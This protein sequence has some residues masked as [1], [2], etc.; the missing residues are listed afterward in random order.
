MV[1]TTR[2]FVSYTV[3]IGNKARKSYENSSRQ[4]GD[5]T[6]LNERDEVDHRLLTFTDMR[7]DPA[8]F[9]LVAHKRER[10]RIDENLGASFACES[11][12]WRGALHF[13]IFFLFTSLQKRSFLGFLDPFHCSIQ[14]LCW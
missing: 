10:A 4:G 6:C 8:K 1:P 7:D 9:F 12:S 11:V 13:L 3:S 5:Q 2:T 14:S